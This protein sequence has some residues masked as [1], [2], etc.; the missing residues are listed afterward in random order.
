MF[1]FFP[2]FLFF[3]S[4]VSIFFLYI[5]YVFYSLIHK[6][7]RVSFVFSF[8]CFYLSYAW[9]IIYF[10]FAIRVHQ[11][12]S[13]SIAITCS[14]EAPHQTSNSSSS[15]TII[16]YKSHLKHILANVC[17]AYQAARYQAVI[18]SPII[19]Y[20]THKLSF[21][22]WGGVMETY[23]GVLEIPHQ[24]EIKTFHCI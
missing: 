4:G 9:V 20:L 11:N 2:T 3:F 5:H 19:C 17:W 10:L 1:F 6:W 23:P 14:I 24:L 16:W 18:G 8:L 12:L 13:F 21:S 22:A 15:L 7:I